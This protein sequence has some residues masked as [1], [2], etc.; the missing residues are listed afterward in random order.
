MNRFQR[1]VA[2]YDEGDFAAALI[3]FRKA[4]DL[5]PSY[6]LL[7][8]IGQ[9]SYK[10]KDYAGALK[11]FERYLVE[12]G[13]KIPPERRAEVQEEVNVLRAQTGRIDVSANVFGASVSIDDTPVG[14]TPL[15]E[16]V[17]VSVGKRKVTVTAPGR[18]PVTRIVDIGGQETEQVKVDLQPLVGE[19]RTVITDRPSKM[20]TWSWVGLGAAGAF[21]I[22]AAVTGVMANN[23][24]D[25]LS[26]MSYIGTAPSSQVKTQQDKVKS[27]ALTTDILAG[28]A[29][30]TLTT[31]LVWTFARPDPAPHV[32]QEPV[33]KR[34]SILPA[35]G[36]GAVGLQGEF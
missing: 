29:I 31:T 12:A 14:T 23:A 19:T 16:P 11:S 17:L 1:A 6:K 28:A 8:K 7:Y 36:L 22:G 33:A 25:D 27:R 18:T 20:T 13:D 9:V 2:L 26:N 24:S 34:P 32:D 10:L 15:E 30:V 35:V 21:G 3:E 4:Y 5:S